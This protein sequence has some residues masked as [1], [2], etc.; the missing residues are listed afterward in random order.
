MT[1]QL[2]KER[3]EQTR[4]DIAKV[5]NTLESVSQRMEW[6]FECNDEWDN[7]IQYQIEDATRLLGMS[8]A[9]LTTWWEGE[10]EEDNQE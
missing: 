8:L 10:D 2:T 4:I 3:I 7:D 6:V 1:D 5:I 9:T